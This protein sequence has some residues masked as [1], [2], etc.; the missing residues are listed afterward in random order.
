MTLAGTPALIAMVALVAEVVESDPREVGLRYEALKRVGVG[1]WMQRL[2]V[3]LADH[4]VGALVAGAPIGARRGQ[5]VKHDETSR[6]DHHR[7]QANPGKE[8]NKHGHQRHQ[9]RG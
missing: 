1:Q 4:E 8:R 7:E 9:D 5:I 3:L 2:A 6:C